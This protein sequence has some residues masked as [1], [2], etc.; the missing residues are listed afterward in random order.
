MD[1]TE[2]KNIAIKCPELK[3]VVND[4]TQ[5]EGRAYIICTLCFGLICLHFRAATTVFCH[6]VL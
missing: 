3:F 4:Q 2:V 1:R 5:N 6:K